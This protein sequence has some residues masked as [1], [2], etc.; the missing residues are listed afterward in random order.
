MTWNTTDALKFQAAVKDNPVVVK[1]TT[2]E[3]IDLMKNGNYIFIS[4]E[5][6][7]AI[8]ELTKY[9][10]IIKITEGM[11]EKTGSYLFH[12]NN[13]LIHEI[14]RAIT[15]NGAFIRRTYYKYFTSGFVFD[16]P[17]RCPAMKEYLSEALRPI[18]K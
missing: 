18:G 1:N 16:K 10:N 13:P 12:P 14:N 2:E 3:A 7:Y 8:F 9:C 5:D 11:P 17:I 4:Q 6:E 15:L